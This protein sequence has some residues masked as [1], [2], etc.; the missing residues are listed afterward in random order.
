MLERQFTASVY[1][2]DQEKV[3]LIYHKKLKKWLPPGGHLDPNEIPPECAKREAKEETGLDVEIISQENIWI[4][5]WNAKSFERPF[6]CLLE[7]I[8]EHNGVAAHQHLDMVYLAYKI[9]GNEEENLFETDGM[10]WFNLD[11]IEKLQSNIEI[12]DETKDVLRL[13]FKTQ[14]MPSIQTVH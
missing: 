4:D 13:I 1:I 3:L 2:I 14:L 12:F 5:R 8:P 7:E 11:E 6:L 10:R 9:G